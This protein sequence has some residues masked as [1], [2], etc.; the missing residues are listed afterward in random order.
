M[1]A[2][3]APDAL[4]DDLDERLDRDVNCR[5]PCLSYSDGTIMALF[6]EWADD[7]VAERARADRAEDMERCRA[8]ELEQECLALSAARADADRLANALRDVKRLAA[9]A[10]CELGRAPDPR[11]AD[12]VDV[13][14][15]SV[16][17]IPSTF[18][19][20]K[21]P[22]NRPLTDDESE[23]IVAA[24]LASRAPAPEPTA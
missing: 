2:P 10:L 11:F 3:D 6:R 17:R 12:L 23:S 18:D 5:L 20:S 16:P 15:R 24:A 4:P 1:I 22:G 21:Y 7:L 9:T 19:P 14:I 8:M 13:D